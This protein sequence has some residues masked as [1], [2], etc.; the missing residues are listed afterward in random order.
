MDRPKRVRHVHTRRVGPNIFAPRSGRLAIGMRALME[1]RQ[2]L[3]NEYPDEIVDC[4]V[5]QD[6]VTIVRNMAARAFICLK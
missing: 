5:C 6:I 2:Y 4:K 1:L 3:K